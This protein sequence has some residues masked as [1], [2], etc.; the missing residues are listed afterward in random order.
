[1]YEK[2]CHQHFDRRKGRGR[3][4]INN[5]CTLTNIMKYLMCCFA[6]PLIIVDIRAR[7]QLCD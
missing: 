7:T 2:V 5:I 3:Q 1:M 6:A 4:I